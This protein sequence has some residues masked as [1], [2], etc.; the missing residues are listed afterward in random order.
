[1]QESYY[2]RTLWC[3][4]QSFLE[5]FIFPFFPYLFFS[6]CPWM[7]YISF[8]TIITWVSLK[9]IQ[10]LLIILGF[11]SDI[12]LMQILL[13][14]LY[15]IKLLICDIDSLIF[16]VLSKWK[17]FHLNL[18]YK[19]LF[20]YYW[21]Q[22][23]IPVL[24]MSYLA[25]YFPKPQL[26]PALSLALSVTLLQKSVSHF[27]TAYLM[28]LPEQVWY[29]YLWIESFQSR[30]IQLISKCWHPIFSVF[31][32]YQISSISLSKMSVKEEQG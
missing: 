17:C 30:S 1:M 22:K 11:V 28:I 21:N 26:F 10:Y 7:E 29:F 15:F 3:Y 16:K 4:V 18:M 27:K 2:S 13:L 23:K 5:L 9:L 19:T 24:N 14:F 6:L 25:S 31:E 8:C 32:V 12:V 20:S